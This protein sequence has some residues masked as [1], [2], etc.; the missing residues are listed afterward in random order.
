MLTQI[1]AGLGGSPV[2]EESYA[3]GY[4]DPGSFLATAAAVAGTGVMAYDCAGRFLVDRGL[5][6]AAASIAAV[7]ARH[8]AYLNLVSGSPP[9][10]GA[11]EEARSPDEISA[12]AEEYIAP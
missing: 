2:A 5:I 6:T 10:P 9:V 7:E 4:T 1:V 11:F 8:A 3:F 12:L